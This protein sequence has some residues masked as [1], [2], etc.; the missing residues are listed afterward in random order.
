MATITHSCPAPLNAI[1]TQVV[2]AWAIGNRGVKRT[3]KGHLVHRTWGGPCGPKVDYGYCPGS[4]TPYPQGVPKNPVVTSELKEIP[5]PPKTPVVT[6]AT[7]K[8]LFLQFS[9]PT[10]AR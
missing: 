2:P 8:P 9:K 10:T 7:F 5:P 1:Q 3:S 4:Y 6:P